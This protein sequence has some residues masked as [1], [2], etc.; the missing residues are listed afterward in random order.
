MKEVRFIYRPSIIVFLLR[1]ILLSVCALGLA[2]KAQNN[3]SGLLYEPLFVLSV[4]EMNIL[5]WY[6]ALAAAIFVFFSLLSLIEAISK[7]LIKDFVNKNE[8]VLTSTTLSMNDKNQFYE[9]IKIKY[10]KI[11]DTNI[12]EING[13][14]FYNIFYYDDNSYHYDGKLTIVQSMLSNKKTFYELV[15]LISKRVT[16]M[17]IR[18]FKDGSEYDLH[19]NV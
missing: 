10:S 9:E 14:C 17:P 13:K 19:L 8:I 11:Y 6:S 1:T 16:N 12:Q 7:G 15:D 18:R 3:D 4:K 2:Y 5:Y